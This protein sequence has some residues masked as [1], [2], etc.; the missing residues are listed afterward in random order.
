MNGDLF[1]LKKIKKPSEKLHDLLTG[2]TV[3]D[4][5]EPAIQSVARKF[6]YDAAVSVL[7][8]PRNK[9]A[10]AIAKLPHS[11]QPLLKEYVIKIHNRR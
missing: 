4:D 11:L 9:R 5:A 6:L 7:R 1:T 3:W 8:L 2:V 10:G